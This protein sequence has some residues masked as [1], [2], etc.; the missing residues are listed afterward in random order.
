MLAKNF[1]TGLKTAVGTVYLAWGPKGLLLIEFPVSSERVFLRSMKNRFG[2]GVDA[3][4]DDRS[5][6]A[7]KTAL[8]RYFDGEREGFKGAAFRETVGKAEGL[9]LFLK[10]LLGCEFI[11][12]S[13]GLVV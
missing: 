5:G 9:F 6:A 12:G 13:L 7:A 11:E 3:V 2:F 4:R 1:Y 10:D 8:R